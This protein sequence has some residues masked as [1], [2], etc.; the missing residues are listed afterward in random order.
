MDCNSY[1]WFYML[2]RKKISFRWVLRCCPSCV[3][4]CKSTVFKVCSLHA[5]CETRQL[6]S[7]QGC[8]RGHN[9][10]VKTSGPLLNVAGVTE[11]LCFLG[12][13]TF[14]FQVASFTGFYCHCNGAHSHIFPSG[15]S[16][17]HCLLI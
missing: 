8:V 17:N 9:T 7:Y 4:I 3:A 12:A 10:D 16:T 14:V 11:A 1:C 15:S 5:T 2:K 13:A 6:Q